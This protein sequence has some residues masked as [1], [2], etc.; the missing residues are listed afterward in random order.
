MA[1]E[2]FPNTVSFLTSVNVTGTLSA[3]NFESPDSPKWNSVYSTVQSNSSTNWNYQ[4]TDLKDLS[5]NWQNAYTEFSNA[6]AS[7]AVTSFVQS[8]FLPLSGGN[9]NGGLT[10]NGDLSSLTIVYSNNGNSNQWSEAFTTVQANSASWS[11]AASYIQR[12]DYVA[13]GVDYSYSGVALGG[14]L[15]SDPFWKI[16]RLG[17]NDVGALSSAGIA[18]NVTWNERL[19]AT[20]I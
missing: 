6:S 1:T 8:N 14:T 13:D 5:A 12:F 9:I 18:Q 3:G 19:T 15:E 7:Y 16:T 11:A 4:G 2:F 10:V 17:F 20:Y